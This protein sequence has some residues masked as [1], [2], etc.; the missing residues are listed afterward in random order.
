MGIKKTFLEENDRGWMKRKQARIEEKKETS[1]RKK[2]VTQNH[3]FWLKFAEKQ[4]RKDSESIHRADRLEENSK[5]TD[6]TVPEKAYCTTNMTP[7]PCITVRSENLNL[8]EHSTIPGN[9][10][11]TIKV[12]VS[13][14]KALGTQPGLNG[15]NSK[16]RP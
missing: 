13:E 12:K 6:S 3:S 1:R 9:T 2:V 5:S 10:G 7:N 11:L 14:N 8:P 15:K 16:R 4:K